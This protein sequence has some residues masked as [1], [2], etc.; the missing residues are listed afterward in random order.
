MQGA[1]SLK[2][3]THP[4]PYQQSPLPAYPKSNRTPHAEPQEFSPWLSALS[5][6]AS[7]KSTAPG[8]P[9]FAKK[10]QFLIVPYHIPLDLGPSGII[11]RVGTLLPL[12]LP[13]SLPGSRGEGN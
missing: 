8:L 3:R 10:S 13:S 4:K 9:Q 11:A 2:T 7:P 5:N 1:E 6:K 12:N